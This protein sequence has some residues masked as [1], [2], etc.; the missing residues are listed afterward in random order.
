MRQPM[1]FAALMQSAPSVVDVLN[2]ALTLEYLE[3]TFYTMGVGASSLIP[4]ADL[5]I[6]QTIQQHESA[7]VDFLKAQIQAMDG[8]PV[9]QPS[10]DFTA[11]G[12]FPDPFSNYSVFQALSQAFEDTG[13]RAYKG[14]A[15][16]LMS[17]AAV[18][19]AALEIHSVEA[20]HASEV[21]RLRGQKGWITGAHT[22]IAGAD[23]IYAGED[24]TSQA[25]VAIDSLPGV[26]GTLGANAASEAFDEPL[27]MEEVLSIVGPFIAA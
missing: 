3:S 12:S 22:D 27:S 4:E 26:S 6:F 17:N 1:I 5:A 23:S 24:A 8:T 7:H 13:V 18:L 20:R 2:Y 21:R 16:N 11:G 10:F 25:G 9:D 19:T 14:Q 15:G